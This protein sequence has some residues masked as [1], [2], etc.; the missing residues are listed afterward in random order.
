MAAAQPEQYANFSALINMMEHLSE[1]WGI[2]DAASR[3]LYMNN[4]AYLYTNTPPSFQIEGRFDGEFPAAWAEYEEEMIEHDRRTQARHGRVA[5]IETHYWF[6][7]KNLM[8]YISEKLPLYDENGIFI[9]VAWNARLLDTM[10]PLKYI[11]QQKP[12]VLTTEANS[13]LFT[14]AELDTL[15]LMLQRLTTKE[16]ARIYKLSHRTVEN[17]IYNIYQKAGV[18]TLGQF[19]EF[20]RHAGLD[21]FI[22]GRLIEKG[23]QFI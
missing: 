22:P 17:R 9:G 18:H 16:I 1:P 3:H 14:R 19:E 8:P 11:S 6:G 20:C 12:G 10:S 15:F 13:D 23:I 7:Q 4:A 21:H 2:K 5:I